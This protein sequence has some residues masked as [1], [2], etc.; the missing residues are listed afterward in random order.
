MIETLDLHFLGID[1]A[2]ASF[3]IP[4]TEGPVLIETGPHSTLRSLEA[5]VQQRGYKLE[6]IRHVLLTHIHLDHAGAAWYLAR[7]GATV[8]LHPFGEAHLA[9]PSKLMDSARRIYKDQMDQLWGDMQPIA[10]QHLRTVKNGEVIGIGGTQFRSIHTPGHARH[11]IAW[12]MDH[13]LFTGDVAGVKIGNGP[14]V[15]PCPPPDIDLEDWN[16]SIDLILNEKPEQLYLT[17][18]GQVLQV[19][20]HM[21]ELRNILNDWAYWIKEKWEQGLSPDAMTPLF[22]AYTANQLRKKGVSEHGIAQ[23]EAANPAWMSVAGL[24]RYWKK[25]A[26]M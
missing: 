20:K 7:H 8:Y 3:L 12:Q 1:H 14:V 15:P 24:I 18:Y 13:V 2:I 25:R 21:D 22:S 6:E 16:R 17:H 10:S 26:E 19:P 23:Y 9:D 5:S 11:H 4:T